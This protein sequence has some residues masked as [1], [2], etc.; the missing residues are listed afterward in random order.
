M[1][2]RP[3]PTIATSDHVLFP[4][5]DINVTFTSDM[6]LAS[7]V[8]GSC[9]KLMKL[10]WSKREMQDLAVGSLLYSWELSRILFC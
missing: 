6:P 5:V 7:A 4:G 9:L 3:T 2:E 8:G 1:D 10:P